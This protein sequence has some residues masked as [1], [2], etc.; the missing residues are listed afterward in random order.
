[1]GDLARILVY[2]DLHLS[3]K[4]Y[5]SHNNYPKETLDILRLITDKASEIQATHIVGLGDFADGSTEKLRAEATGR[6]FDWIFGNRK[7][8]DS[9]DLGKLARAI[10]NGFSPGYA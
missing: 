1:M 8:N 9:R 4:N 6:L 3:S 7:I 5:G 10:G 2:G